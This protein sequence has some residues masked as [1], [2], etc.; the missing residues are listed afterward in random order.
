[1]ELNKYLFE[2]IYSAVGHSS[3]MDAVAIF[4]AEYFTYLLIAGVAFWILSRG[5]K[6]II[7]SVFSFV[8]L[9]VLFSRGIITEVIRY[10]Y[11]SPRPFTALGFEPLIFD[12]NQSFPSGHTAFLFAFAFSIFLI[13]KKF[14]IWL[15]VAGLLVA[16]ARIYAGVHWPFD[17]LGGVVVALIGTFIAHF[18]LKKFTG[19]N[20]A[21]KSNE[22]SGE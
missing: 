22:V 10:F 14:G 17:I 18:L 3:F 7:F 12:G 21:L 9:S 2:K 20:P 4:F 11:K 16:L 15:A 6:K 1:M 8:F 19:S 5:G 13:N